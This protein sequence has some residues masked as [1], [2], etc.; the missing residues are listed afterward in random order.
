MIDYA[1]L[2]VTVTRTPGLA[3]G[4]LIPPIF[5]LEEMAHHSDD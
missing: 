3:C 1:A 4:T 2:C 5:N